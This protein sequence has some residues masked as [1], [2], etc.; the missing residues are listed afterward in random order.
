M[1]KALVQSS[2]HEL[3]TQK[4]YLRFIR[5]KYGRKKEKERERKKKGRD[6]EKKTETKRKKEKEYDTYKAQVAQLVCL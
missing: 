5:V 6:R 2:S 1:S 4:F 3:Y